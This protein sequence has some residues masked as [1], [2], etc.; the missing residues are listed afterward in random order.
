MLNDTHS[1]AASFRNILKPVALTPV[2]TLYCLA[3]YINTV[4]KY[5]QED[6][7]FIETHLAIL[8]Y[9]TITTTHVQFNYDV[10]QVSDEKHLNTFTKNSILL[11]QQNFI[12][13]LNQQNKARY[14]CLKRQKQPQI[15]S[16]PRLI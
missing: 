16:A 3:T 9:Q 5:K 14:I 12:F 10:T 7:F 4:T 13:N 1:A 8:H 15:T 2:N 11:I 6:N